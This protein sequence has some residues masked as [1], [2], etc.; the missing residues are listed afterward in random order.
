MMSVPE[1]EFVELLGSVASYNDKGH[2][3]MGHTRERQDAFLKAA[4][5]ELRRLADAIGEQRLGPELWEAVLSGAA[6]DD[7][8]GDFRVLAARIFGRV[9]GVHE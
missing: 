3:W 1:A 4:S 2:I 5:E 6:I 8:S 7:A 9:G